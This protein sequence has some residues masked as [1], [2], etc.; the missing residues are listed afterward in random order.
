MSVAQRFYLNEVGV[1]CALGDDTRSVYAAMM[2]GDQSGMIRTDCFSPDAPCVVGR[3]RA[4][5]GR[6]HG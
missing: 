2:A 5:G 3:V 4:A 6:V 1:V